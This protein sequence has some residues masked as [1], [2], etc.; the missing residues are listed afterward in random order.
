VSGE[1][2]GGEDGYLTSSQPPSG[3]IEYHHLIPRT[4]RP[5]ILRRSPYFYDRIMEL[6]GA[7]GTSLTADR[8][9][10]EPRHSGEL[11]KYAYM[12]SPPI[13][14]YS[15]SSLGL[16]L[17]RNRGWTGTTTVPDPSKEEPDAV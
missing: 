15:L 4:P 3:V 8:V 16:E 12:P 5:W 11:R 6:Q 2:L 9:L 13:T 1:E 7:R 17:H 14:G 10:T